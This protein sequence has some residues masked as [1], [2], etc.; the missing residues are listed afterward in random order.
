MVAYSWTKLLLDRSTP[1]THYDAILEDAAGMGI[2]KLPEGQTAVQVVAE[3]LSHVYHHII[4]AIAKQI[5]DATLQI[6]PL[7]F[8]FTVPAIW[9]DDAKDATMKAALRAGFATRCGHV[10]DKIFLITEPEAAAITALRKS[11]RDGSSVKV[12]SSPACL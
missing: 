6:T 11:T 2:F 1:V 5:K 3:F 4:G 8:W 9:S 10:Q 12:S 7:E